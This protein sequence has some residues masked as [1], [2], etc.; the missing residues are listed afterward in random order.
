MPTV[1]VII[2]NYNHEAFL[3]QR[4]NSVLNQTY[5]DFEVIILD[6]HS[7]DN[8]SR[9][10]EAYRDHPKV[11]H[12]IY[13]AANSGSTFK[14]WQK[15]LESATGQYIWIAESDDYCDNSFLSTAMENLTAH[16]SSLFFCQ[17][18]EVDEAGTVKG[19]YRDPADE[20]WN[21]G[22]TLSG[23]QFVFNYMQF[24]NAIVNASAVVFKNR[25]FDFSKVTRYR[26]CGDWLFWVNLILSDK[27]VVSYCH[28]KLNYFRSHAG[29]TRRFGN[30][31]KEVQRST[32]EASVIFE[33]YAK[34]IITKNRFL[35]LFNRKI[36]GSLTYFGLFK[37]T[38]NQLSAPKVLVIYFLKRKC[39]RRLLQSQASVKNVLRKAYRKVYPLA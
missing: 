24:G 7:T 11:K 16:G 38:C 21:A 3:K 13:N 8:S 27:S 36:E 28:Q 34:S 29:T 32:E 30:S 1:S 33:L 18:Y 31:F 9:I 39:Q 2:P 12:I 4:I 14:Q 37:N 20:V 23:R 19:D 22:F 10:I 35:Y 26:T 5:A 15:G 17:S 6:D 25:Q